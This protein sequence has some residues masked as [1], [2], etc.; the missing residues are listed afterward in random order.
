MPTIFGARAI[1]EAI[2]AGQTLNKLYISETAQGASLAVAGLARKQG[3]PVQQVPMERIERLARGKNHQGVAAETAAVDYAELETILPILFAKKVTP[4]FIV[5]DRVTDVR[6]L[7]GIA[8]TALAAGVNAIIVPKQRAA[9][10]SDDAMKASAGALAHLPICRVDD[11]KKAL[12]Y[13]K[14]NNV[15][16]LGVTE[17]AR[18]SLYSVQ[19]EGPMAIL[20]GS[21]EDGIRQELLRL[22]DASV[23][24]PMAGPLG[25][26]NVGAATSIAL[27]EYVR[28]RAERDGS[29]AEGAATEQAYDDEMAQQADAERA[30]PDSTDSSLDF[31]EEE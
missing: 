27:F 24:I 15:G 19:L 14:D 10:V 4:L 1:E 9:Q 28:Q 25:S 7:G 6:N 31:S 22:C 2:L 18:K 13:L 26:L 5:L 3:F 23:R 17:K 20:M 29:T 16:I 30:E 12:Y 8:R 11:L 21:E